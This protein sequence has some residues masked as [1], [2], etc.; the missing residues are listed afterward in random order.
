[1]NTFIS[2]LKNCHFFSLFFF[3]FFKMSIN[4]PIN[5]LNDIE[6]MLV[7]GRFDGFDEL[8]NY[9]S[10]NYLKVPCLEYLIKKI[11]FNCLDCCTD[12]YSIY[13]EKCFNPEE[14]KGH[15]IKFDIPNG[16]C[17]CGLPNLHVKP[18]KI[19]KQCLEPDPNIKLSFDEET[20]N[21]I[22]PILKKISGL[23]QNCTSQEELNIVLFWFKKV[24]MTCMPMLNCACEAFFSSYSYEEIVRKFIVNNYSSQFFY[25]L[26]YFCFASESA[27]KHFPSLVYTIYENQDSDYFY[28]RGLSI[29]AALI[30]SFRSAFDAN[31]FFANE[32]HDWIGFFSLILQNIGNSKLNAISL[33]FIEL[34]IPYFHESSQYQDIIESLL[35]TYS[36]SL[37][38]YNPILRPSSILSL[39]NDEIEGS[40]LRSMINYMNNLFYSVI[41]FPENI[42]DLR[43][44]TQLQEFIRY[45]QPFIFKDLEIYSRRIFYLTCLTQSL[46]GPDDISPSI[47]E[48]SVTQPEDFMHII[49]SIIFFDIM[50]NAI[51]NLPYFMYFGNFT[52]DKILDN[53]IR[54]KDKLFQQV[55]NYCTQEYPSNKL[56]PKE[57]NEFNFF[58]NFV[59]QP[60]IINLCQSVTEYYKQL[61]RLPVMSKESQ[62]EYLHCQEYIY[63]EKFQDICISFVYNNI[64]SFKKLSYGIPIIQY[65]YDHATDSSK[66]PVFSQ[67]FSKDKL[68][69][70]YKAF[71]QL[72]EKHISEISP[73]PKPILG[74]EIKL[75]KGPLLTKIL[76]N[77]K[78][79]YR[80]EYSFINDKSAKTSNIKL[81]I[82]QGKYDNEFVG[83]AMTFIFKCSGY[84]N[85]LE[86]LLEEIDILEKRHLLNNNCFKEDLEFLKILYY[87]FC[88]INTAKSSLEF[89]SSSKQ[90]SFYDLYDCVVS[91]ILQKGKISYTDIIH[92]AF[93]KYDNNKNN[94]LVILRKSIIF[95]SICLNSSNNDFS[96]IDWDNILS[97]NNLEKVFK[98]K[99]PENSIILQKYRFPFQIPN[100][101]IEFAFKP[102]F[103]NLSPRAVPKFICLLNGNIILNIIADSQQYQ[104]MNIPYLAMQGPYAT[105]L[106]IGNGK[107]IEYLNSPYANHFG[108]RDIGLQSL[109]VPKLDE[110]M[111]DREIDRFLQMNRKKH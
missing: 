65:L 61:I 44:N 9:Y 11:A 104:G 43:E 21:L 18:C 91:F 89:Y 55:M 105:A 39:I 60:S 111:F 4:S 83:K 109:F 54:T 76:E 36:S 107:I 70:V 106:C 93:H 87:I 85:T 68:E 26:H 24:Y 67:K 29:F 96:N 45:F 14:H 31:Q 52:L 97:L 48:L 8:L 98:V 95:M 108:N 50:P 82:F 101:Y 71:N 63:L 20:Y 34:F 99:V 25:M 27:I 5:I 62:P 72:L 10:K 94:L 41:N 49:A 88:C 110:Q 90:K 23:L 2:L 16:F 66:G 13:C 3:F 28:I 17:D 22:F 69:N 7:N 84:R 75:V 15:H 35:L 38:V 37:I 19:H 59:S 81:P 46:F 86:I 40:D 79:P 12:Q 64:N 102:Y 58:N 6:N 33:D 100:D 32:D 57:F 42:Q 77:G 74:Y 78:T 1:M 47:L 51:Q 80:F 73:Q 30:V 56:I 103:L 92:D 53:P